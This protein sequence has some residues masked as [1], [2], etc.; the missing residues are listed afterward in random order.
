MPAASVAS[1]VLHPLVP[2]TASFWHTDLEIANE[3]E[4]A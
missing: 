2:G 3:E 1:N 4:G